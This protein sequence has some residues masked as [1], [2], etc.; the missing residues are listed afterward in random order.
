MSGAHD[1]RFME[2][3]Q[4]SLDFALV[5]LAGTQNPTPDDLDRAVSL[6]LRTAT[7]LFP[8]VEM[9]ERTLRRAVEASVSVFVGEASALGDNRGHVAWLNRRRSEI[10]WR[11]WNAYRRYQITQG[12]PL[13]VVS[14]LDGITDDV[15]GR[16]ESPDR[17]GAWDRRG[18]VVGQVQSGKTS[19]YTGLVAKAADAGYKVIVVLAGMHNSLRSQTQRRLDE[20][21][22]GLDSRTGPGFTGT[23]R[24]IGVGAGGVRH[25]SA[26]SLTSMDEIGDFAK[27]IASRITTRIDRTHPPVLL[28]VKKNATIL[29]NLIDWITPLHERPHPESGRMVVP[30]LPLLVIDDEADHASVNTKDVELDV[31]EDGKVISETD[32]T[33]INRLIRK[34]LFAFEQSAYVGYTATPFANIFIYED[35]ESPTY[36]EDLF[37]RSFI[38]RIPPPSNYM[39]PA[40]V[41]GIAAKD[42]PRGQER[43]GLP[44]LRPVE[45]ADNW[46]PPKHKK[47]LVPGRLPPSLRKAMRSFVLTCAARAARGQRNVHNSML[48]HVT[49][50]IN[51][52]ALVTEQVERELRKVQNQLRYGD[53]EGAP[54]LWE[55]LREIWETDYVP[56]T[57]AIPEDVRGDPVSWEQV[58]AELPDAAARIS[59]RQINGTAGD[60]LEYTDSPDGTSVIAIGGDKLSRGLTLEGLT[61]SYYLRASK[62]YDTLMQMGRW[63]GYRPGYTD[64]CRLYTTR[65]LQLAYRNITIASEELLVK[66]DEMAASGATPE[67]FALYV[68]TSPDGLM[69]TAPAKMRRST[70]LEMTFSENIV[71]TT[72]FQRVK[73]QQQANLRVVED[74]ITRQEEARRRIAPSPS[75]NFRWDVVPGKEVAQLL[76]GWRTADT[77]QKARGPVLAQYIESRVAAHELKHWMVGLV[78]R[79]DAQV[80][81]PLA[82]LTVGLTERGP[83]L[84]VDPPPEMFVIGRLVNPPDERMDMSDKQV[85]EALRKTQDLWDRGKSRAKS[86]PKTPSGSSIRG[87]RSPQRGLLMLYPMDPK[88][89]DLDGFTGPL[90]GF[91]VSFPHSPNAP[92]ISYLV[93]ARYWQTDFG[94]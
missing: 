25:P 56:T 46:I 34:L 47:H 33:T 38:I 1:E 19:N 26:L 7:D 61:V 82:G 35:K 9:D 57:A 91:A 93:P 94:F 39:G 20:G 90:M 58:A 44:I 6:S 8:D 72:I 11:F 85:A 79:R 53:G 16:L 14:R 36:G 68:R 63:F 75:G 50:F 88:Q 30:D 18:M 28:V 65:D 55:A 12:M 62:M 13:E 66:F 24:A 87:V 84:D 49:R 43:P 64:L 40:E 80:T 86:R 67:R 27:G 31:D 74:F 21:F 89:M 54:E 5:V 42:D 78:H 76:A 51:V 32:P 81:A 2:A 48:V 4:K 29:N 45:D 3:A 69:V 59:I 70:K 41:F 15:L 60:A 17:A 71:E 83:D 22:L 37:P 92:T 77:A 52:Q 23:K 73:E 10:D